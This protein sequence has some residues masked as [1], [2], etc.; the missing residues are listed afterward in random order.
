MGEE[1]ILAYL[2]SDFA[3]TWCLATNNACVTNMRPVLSRYTYYTL[4]GLGDAFR[5]PLWLKRSLTRLQLSQFFLV[6]G[7]CVWTLFSVLT[8]G[9]SWPLWMAY[10]FSVLSSRTIRAHAYVPRALLPRA[11]L[12]FFL[13]LVP[14]LHCLR[15]SL[16]FLFLFRSCLSAVCIFL[17]EACH[18]P[19]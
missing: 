17:T 5:P 8:R 14:S 9:C 12:S 10:V 6:I 11:P 7:H 4:A 1:V 3:C 18:W 2:S 13:A 16:S 19:C 15:A